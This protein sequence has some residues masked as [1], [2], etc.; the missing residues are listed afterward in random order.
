MSYWSRRSNS[1]E[2]ENVD[3][4]NQACIHHY[5][6]QSLNQFMQL[7]FIW[8]VTNLCVIVHYIS[9]SKENAW[10]YYIKIINQWCLSCSKTTQQN[11]NNEPLQTNSSTASCLTSVTTSHKVLDHSAEHCNQCT[12]N[13]M[14]PVIILVL[15]KFSV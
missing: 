4:S 9:L 5:M 13:C 12:K 10:R 15:K 1:W 2:K 8:F 14:L 11:A 3:V 6:T 7:D